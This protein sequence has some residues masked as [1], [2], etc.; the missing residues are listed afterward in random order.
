[1]NLKYIAESILNRRNS[2]SALN[3]EAE[4][5]SKLN[6]EQLAEALKRGW[7]IQDEEFGCLSAS[8]LP[9]RIREIR[10]AA[11]SKEDGRAPL[12]ESGR[13]ENAGSSLFRSLLE[14]KSTS[15]LKQ[16]VREDDANTG[17]HSV[18]DKVM[19]GQD[20]ESYDGVVSEVLPTGEYKVTF[21]EKKPKEEKNYKN[22]E[23]TKPAT[24]SPTAPG[25]SAPKAGI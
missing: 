6:H 5:K 25:V 8:N 1:M 22:T 17:R 15:H 11:E 2:L 21:G 19:V 4:L 9:S 18:G 13:K 3:I 16:W 10:E 20:G 24:A 14:T 7:L 12:Q 23:L